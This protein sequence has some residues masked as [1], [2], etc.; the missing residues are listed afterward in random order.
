ML[1]R[2]IQ[3]FEQQ[4]EIVREIGDRRGEGADLWNMSVARDQLGE[5]DQAIRD[6]ELALFIFEQIEDPHAAQVRA[7]LDAWREERKA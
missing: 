6:A 1:P 7:Q 2:A 4:L 5:R 3:F